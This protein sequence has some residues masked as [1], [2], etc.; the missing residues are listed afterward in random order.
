MLIPTALTLSPP[1]T[2]QAKCPKAAPSRPLVPCSSC[3]VVHTLWQ[4]C[5]SPARKGS[6]VGSRSRARLFNTTRHNKGLDKYARE[7]RL[8]SRR[9][10]HQGNEQDQQQQ[11]KRDTSA[12]RQHEGIDAGKSQNEH[13]VKP[14]INT[15]A[16]QSSALCRDRRVRHEGRHWGSAPPCRKLSIACHE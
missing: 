7:R 15:H 13:V 12:T 14:S 2:N 1:F 5:L 10:S 6:S 8:F 3:N 11:T 9:T 16:H 4:P